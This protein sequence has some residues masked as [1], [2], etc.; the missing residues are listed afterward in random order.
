[1]RSLA[2]AALWCLTG[3]AG[4]P[5]NPAD[6]LAALAADPHAHLSGPVVA[7]GPAR[8]LNREDF[9]YDAKLS[10]DAKLVAL[11][12]LG[13]KEFHLAIHDLRE[14]KPRSDQALNAYEF[15]VDT[16][17]FSPDGQ[18]VAA[19]SRDGSLRIS[20]ALTGTPEAAWLTEEPL[21]SVAWAPDGQL[22]A[23]GS[24]KGLVT[25]V[26]FPTLSHVAELRAHADEVRALAFTPAGELVS[27]GWDKRVVLFSVVPLA[28]PGKDVRTHV[29]RNRGVTSVRAVVEA[30]AS[31]SF[32][33]DARSPVNLVRASLAQA[34]GLDVQGLGETVTVPTALGAQLAKLARGRALSL[35]GLTFEGVDLVVCDVC[36]P[37]DVD[38]VLGAPWFDRA[39]VV[40]DDATAEAVV[41]AREGATGV[42]LSAVRSLAKLRDFTFAGAVNDLS[43][44]AT[45]TRAALA[46]SE[47]KAER[48]KAIYDREKRGEVEPLR[49]WDCAVLVELSSGKLLQKQGGHHG[50][51]AT[52]A[53]SPDGQ[54]LASGG[55]DHRVVV[56]GERELVDDSFGLSIRRVRFSRDGRWLL[57][58]AWSPANPL[59]DHQSDPAAV[60]HEVIYR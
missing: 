33:L 14:P 31:A 43:L 56:H 34:A 45:G 9:I 58:G 30:R 3:C 10:P 18:H 38:G 40:F 53:V 39:Q 50:V 54:T 37:P 6:K 23:L 29:T 21:V 47:T 42:S 27:G 5:V 35:K 8:V 2:L 36:V 25:L 19:V 16:V 48:T 26:S 22:L 20:S 24:A 57:I 1:M 52:A 59:G 32:A 7:L 41:S 17:E 55:W 28:S 60:L 13:L 51:V 4:L 11:S 49:E 12:R 44:D 46:L 15:D